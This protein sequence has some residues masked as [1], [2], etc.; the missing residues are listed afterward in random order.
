MRIKHL[1]VGMLIVLPMAA[2]AAEADLYL[3]MLDATRRDLLIDNEGAK[4]ID[5][6]VTA[7]ILGSYEPEGKDL[8][9]ED[10][11]LALENNPLFCGLPTDTEEDAAEADL[12]IFGGCL[13]AQETIQ[14]LAQRE[15][16]TRT[17]AVD[18]QIVA[19]GNELNAPVNTD[20]PD[21]LQNRARALARIWRAGAGDIDADANATLIRMRDL[22]EDGGMMQNVSNLMSA[23]DALSPEERVAAVWR[24]TEGGYHYVSGQRVPQFAPPLEDP[25]D[26]DGTERQYLFKR[27]PDVEAALQAIHESARDMADDPEPLRQRELLVF[28]IPDSI[29][30][31]LDAD[32][33]LWV[34]LEREGD[35]IGGDA[36]VAWNPALEPVLP[37]LCEDGTDCEAIPGGAYPPPPQDGGGLCTGPYARL[38]YLCR[39]LPTEN[40]DECEE[41]VEPEAGTIIL[42]AC[43][44]KLPREITTAGPEACM[45]IDWHAEAFNPIKQ[46]RVEVTCDDGTPLTG[47]TSPK[48]PDGTVKVRIKTAPDTPAPYILIHELV[49]ARQLCGQPPGTMLYSPPGGGDDAKTLM[50][51]RDACCYTEGEAYKA[52]CEAMAAD[53]VFEGNPISP[54]TGIPMNAETCWQIFVDASCQERGYGSCPSAFSYETVPLDQQFAFAKD[55]LALSFDRAPD[56]MP[57]TCADQMDPP[58]GKEADSRVAGQL[59]AA[60]QLGRETCDPNQTVSYENTIGNNVCYFD[61]CLEESFRYRAV[62]GRNT[63]TVG[64]ATAPHDVC[65]VP[66]PQPG[67]L[68]VKHQIQPPDAAIPAYRPALVIRQVENALCTGSTPQ[69]LPILCAFDPQ[70]SIRLGGTLPAISLDIGAETQSRDDENE[71]ALAAIPALGARIGTR[72]YVDYLTQATLALADMTEN[73]AALLT[74]FTTIEFPTVMCPFNDFEGNGLINAQ[75][76]AQ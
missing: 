54:S 28:N 63:Y 52:Q 61:R 49:H 57:L 59:R 3:R 56:W 23:L 34:Y 42:T 67:G 38:G 1:L 64:D 22:P 33:R 70:K 7:F 62:A 50:Q 2:H 6:E 48:M 16:D 66:D 46:C 74:G 19:A 47:Q 44:S 65:L 25:S 14:I 8:T 68:I 45:N 5:P 36:G 43:T 12:D 4:T 24:Y 76:P 21:S 30:A 72:L 29:R 71:A 27:W 11:P 17:F 18:L 75:C 53:G 9:E 55:V 35:E 69:G 40:T 32:I 73:A 31:G 60:E 15:M 39:P 37:S 13:A 10:I 26:P 51:K 20:T 58:D 41:E